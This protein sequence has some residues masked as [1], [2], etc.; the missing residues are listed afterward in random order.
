MF[1]GLFPEMQAVI[2]FFAAQKDCV[3]IILFDIADNNPH[4]YISTRSTVDLHYL[5][6]IQNKYLL[7]Q[8][9]KDYVLGALVC[10]FVCLVLC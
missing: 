7:P 10:L 5:T 4:G 6:I 9:K 2:H 8:S 1:V 3:T